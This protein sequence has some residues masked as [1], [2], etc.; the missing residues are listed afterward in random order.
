MSSILLEENSKQPSLKHTKHMDI[1][2][3]YIT[4]HIQTK[5]CL[6]EFCPTKEMLANF[7]TKPLQGAL[8]VK[9]WNFIIGAEYVNPNCHTHRI[10]LDEADGSHMNNEHGSWH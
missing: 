4:E 5:T 8:F 1:H 2:F 7:L 6:V 10:V 3:F 9:L